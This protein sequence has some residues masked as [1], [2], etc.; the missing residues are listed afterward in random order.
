MTRA[1]LK[2]IIADLQ[3]AHPDVKIELN[4]RLSTRGGLYDTP[5]FRVSIKLP[6]VHDVYFAT[7]D[8][9][10]VASVVERIEE[11]MTTLI[12]LTSERGILRTR[13]ARMMQE[14]ARAAAA[15][16]LLTPPIPPPIPQPRLDPPPVAIPRAAV[17]SASPPGS[18]LWERLESSDED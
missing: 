6:V 1:E 17:S 2:A 18:S 3:A 7:E 11:E 4:R 5:G 12:E 9:W 8:A 15:E 13:A 10:D 14:S 16:R